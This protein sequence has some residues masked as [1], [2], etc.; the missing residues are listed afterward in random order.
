MHECRSIV[1]K[2]PHQFEES[3]FAVLANMSQMVVREVEKGGLLNKQVHPCAAE[4]TKCL[5]VRNL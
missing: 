1:D 2:E 3:S 5:H 4:G